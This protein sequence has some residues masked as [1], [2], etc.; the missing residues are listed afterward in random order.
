MLLLWLD[1]AVLAGLRRISN[2][3]A[4]GRCVNAFCSTKRQCSQ[5]AELWASVTSSLL[6]RLRVRDII[7]FRNHMRVLKMLAVRGKDHTVYWIHR[8]GQLRLSA[9]SGCS[10]VSSWI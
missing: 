9:L 10:S 8:A 1:T 4:A 7:G 3:A 5:T 6:A 2:T